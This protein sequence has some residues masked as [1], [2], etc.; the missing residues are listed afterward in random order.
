MNARTLRRLGVLLVVLVA[1]WLGVGMLRRAGRDTERRLTLA[2][3]DPKAVDHLWIVAATD[4]LR[5]DRVA[6]AAPRRAGAARGPAWDV[7]GLPADGS[8]V[9]DLLASLADTG[10]QSELVGE[11]AASLHALGLDSAAARRVTVLEGSRTVL[12][13]LVGRQAQ[14][15]GTVYVRRPGENASYQL[16]GRLSDL[17]YR[18][19]D[20]WRDK[21]VAAIAPENIA[22]IEVQRASDRYTLSRSGASWRLGSRDADTLK[23]GALLSRFRDLAAIGFATAAQADSFARRKPGEKGMRVVRV[24]DSGGKPLLALT[25][26]STSGGWWARREGDSTTF[27]LDGFTADG[28]TPA[29]STLR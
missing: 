11:Q 25:L 28:V 20:D 13:L 29:D 21:L 24:L 1:V 6:A 17:A 4:T 19:L 7:N 3:F 5:F 26:D 14:G 23:V 16:S 10:A 9:T 8:E 2:R 18:R 22:R 15:Y 27:K 12:E